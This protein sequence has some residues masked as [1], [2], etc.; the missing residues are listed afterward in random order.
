MSVTYNSYVYSST[1][2][3]KSPSFNPVINDE[4]KPLQ[5]IADEK[6]KV[7]EYEA[8]KVHLPSLLCIMSIGFIANCEYGVVMPSVCSVIVSESLCMHVWPADCQTI[9]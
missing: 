7:V 1:P 3:L 5:Q 2:E 6:P 9:C 4:E 8:P